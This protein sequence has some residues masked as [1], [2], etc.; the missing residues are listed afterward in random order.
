MTQ[1]EVIAS[2]SA[3]VGY[4]AGAVEPCQDRKDVE[5]ALTRVAEYI[6]RGMT[7]TDSETDS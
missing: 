5:Q 4:L 3:A 6:T 1:L 2:I 7:D